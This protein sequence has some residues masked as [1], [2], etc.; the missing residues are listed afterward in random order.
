[1]GNY[2]VNRR[3]I[4]VVTAPIVQAPIDEVTQVDLVEDDVEMA[5]RLTAGA[6]V[7]A[8]TTNMSQP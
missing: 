8:V 4:L 6:C 5:Y 3:L 2:G 1:M 7:V